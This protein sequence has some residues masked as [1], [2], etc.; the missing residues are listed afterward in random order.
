MHVLV[1]S[2]LSYLR[3]YA[4]ARP[5]NLPRWTS[6]MSKAANNHSSTPRSQLFRY[7]RIPTRRCVSQAFQPQYN[8]GDAQRR[9]PSATPITSLASTRR[10]CAATRE[11]VLPSTNM[12]RL[13]VAYELPY[14]CRRRQLES[15]Q[16]LLR[17]HV[18]SKWQLVGTP[19]R[20][21]ARLNMQPQGCGP[22]ETSRPSGPSTSSA[23]LAIPA[24]I[25]TGNPHSR[26]L[27]PSLP[28]LAVHL[29]H[30]PELDRSSK[31]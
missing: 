18:S 20:F 7:R 19:W 17:D 31:I 3:R 12:L 11:G 14:S 15:S 30:S 16:I 28:R 1:S 22:P 4:T 8:G 27:W 6:W 23:L 24:L 10:T 29:L 13:H 21:H 2:V 5:P 9:K 25:L 26:I